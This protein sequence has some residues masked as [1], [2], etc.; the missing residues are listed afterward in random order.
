MFTKLRLALVAA[1]LLIGGTA[2]L[3]MAKGGRFDHK[4]QFDT[5]QDGTLDAAER[6]LA[7]TEAYFAAK[8]AHDGRRG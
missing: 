3:A 8:R 6:E 5:N 2:G 1:A 4:K 7:T